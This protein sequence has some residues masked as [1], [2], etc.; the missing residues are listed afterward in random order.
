MEEQITGDPVI[1]EMYRQTQ[2]KPPVE[3]IIRTDIVASMFNR[4]TPPKRVVDLAC[5]HRAITKNRYRVGCVACHAMM[6]NGED[7]DAFRNRER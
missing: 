4:F 3:H 2:P 1:A 7:Y 6:L 5:G